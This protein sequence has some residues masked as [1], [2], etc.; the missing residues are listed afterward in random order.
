MKNRHS[1]GSDM[2]KAKT[3]AH[4]LVQQDNWVAID[5]ET[6]GLGTNAEVVEVAIVS[7][8]GDTLLDSLVRPHTRPEPA[9]SRLHGLY[10]EELRDAPPFEQVHLVLV[11]LL[12]RPIAVAYNAAFDQHALNYSC[13]IAGLPQIG[14]TWACAML[15]YEQWRGFRA[16]LATACEVEGVSSTGQHHRALSDAQHVWRLVRRMAGEPS[17]R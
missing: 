10:S 5:V 9:A 8:S 11:A 3:W 15:R 17:L 4:H 16:S 13:A 6:T 14:C 1:R 12:R 2:A 7:A